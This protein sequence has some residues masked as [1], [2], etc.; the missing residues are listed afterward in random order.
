[1]TLESMNGLTWAPQWCCRAEGPF[2][3]VAK[4]SSVNPLSFSDICQAAFGA[5]WQ[6]GWQYHTF[7]STRW[8][9]NR[10]DRVLTPFES[11]LSDAA[12]DKL[13]GHWALEIAHAYHFRY[14]PTCLSLGFQSALCQI[15]AMVKCPLHHEDLLDHCVMC[16]KTTPAYSLEGAWQFGFHCKTCGQPM[17]SPWEV[18]LASKYA[19][20]EMSEAYTELER[21]L[22]PLKFTALLERISWNREISS[23]GFYERQ[24]ARFKF[25]QEALIPEMDK[26]VIA[27]G[28]DPFAL[29]SLG[30]CPIGPPL[31]KYT[32]VVRRKEVYADLRASLKPYHPPSDLSSRQLGAYIRINHERQ[33]VLP[34]PGIEPEQLASCLFRFRFERCASPFTEWSGD[35]IEFRLRWIKWPG[36]EAIADWQWQRFLENCYEAELRFAKFWCKNTEG[37]DSKSARWRSLLTRYAPYFHAEIAPG[38]GMLFSSLPPHEKCQLFM[39]IAP[40][41]SFLDA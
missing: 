39:A 31:T 16:K 6:K 23:Y 30:T 5:R 9:A 28:H 14:C 32:S 13:V 24:I 19:T 40:H 21:Q 15:T 3:A 33:R 27:G 41:T 12:L 29:V 4:L 20:S 38:V 26:R 11:R 36:V 25:L 34:V 8:L 37:L 18:G 10:K 7:L 17:G 35:E 1:M 22:L 2:T